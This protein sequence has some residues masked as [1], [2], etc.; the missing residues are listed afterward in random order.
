MNYSI[1]NM[2]GVGVCDA[3]GGVAFI[4]NPPSQLERTGIDEWL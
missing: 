3:L 1:I 2:E 4:C